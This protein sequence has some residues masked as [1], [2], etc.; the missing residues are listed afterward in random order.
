MSAQ[1]RLL[2]RTACDRWVNVTV[3]V[4]F[5]SLFPVSSMSMSILGG[6]DDIDSLIWFPNGQ[7]RPVADSI[8]LASAV[9]KVSKL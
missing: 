5:P 8:F 3:M 7:L 9:A 6:N 2:D 1:L 4:I